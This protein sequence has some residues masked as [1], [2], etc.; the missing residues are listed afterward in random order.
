MY[1]PDKLRRL[2]FSAASEFLLETRK[3]YLKPRTFYGYEQHRER[4]KPFFGTQL[5]TKIHIGGIRQYQQLRLTNGGN[6][7]G[8]VA[9]PSIINHEI[10]FLQ[11]VLGRAGEWKK[12]ADHYEPLPVPRRKK[13]QIMTDAEEMLLWAVASSNPDWKLAYLMASISVNTGAAGS[14]LRNL[15]LVELHLDART[16]GFTIN[17]ETA[18]NKFRARWVPLNQTAL[19][20]IR[21]CIEIANKKGSCKGPHYLF[22]FRVCRGHFDPT[23][24]ATASLLRRQWKDMVEAVGIPHITPHCMRHQH[25]TVSLEGGESEFTVAKRMGHRNPTMLREIYGHGREDVQMPAVEAIDPAVR[26]APKS[27]PAWKKKWMIQ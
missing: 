15:T 21:E 11:Q 9:G 18:K 17:A 2:N 4:L 14:E 24:P 25:A 6:M 26:F 7:W 19:S 8:E 1:D 27:V 16:P 20:N 23:R 3:P 13:P 5:L 10:V 12:L 22:P